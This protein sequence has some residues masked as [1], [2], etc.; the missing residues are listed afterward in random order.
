MEVYREEDEVGQQEGVEGVEGS[1]T[2]LAHK[3]CEVS[4]GGGC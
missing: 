4:L 2:S 1:M 3:G